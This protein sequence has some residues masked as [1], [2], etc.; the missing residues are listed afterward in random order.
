[1]DIRTEEVAEGIY[2]F[3]AFVPDIGP[4]GFTFNQYLIVDEEPLLFHTGLRHMFPEVTEAIAALTPVEGLRWVMFGHL[5]ADENGS[6]NELLA[7]APRAEVSHGMTGC[8]V[9]LNDLALRPPVPLADGQVVGLG[10]HRVRHIDT[11]H[12]PHGWEARVLFEE[13]T[14]TLLCG[15]LFTQLGDGP[16]VT[17]DDIV[18]AASQAEDVFGASCLTPTTGSTMRGLAALSPS[19]LAVM[20]GSCFSGD[21]AA[22]LLA[23]ADNYDARL[24]AASV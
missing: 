2:R 1:M 21:G 11:P 6:M 7:V 5:E 20:H 4:T 10:A 23:L 14:G 13:T 24:R 18:E 3:S 16:A 19:T 8:M 22:A 17:T 9:S 15:D 12:V